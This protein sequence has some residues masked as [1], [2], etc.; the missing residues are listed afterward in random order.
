MSKKHIVLWVLVGWGIAYLFPP[1]R[2]LG[3]FKKGGGA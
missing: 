2:V 3:F 1:Q